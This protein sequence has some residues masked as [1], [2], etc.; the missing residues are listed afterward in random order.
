MVGSW[1]V[2]GTMFAS[3]YS[4]VMNNPQTLD[5][6]KWSDLGDAIVKLAVLF[7]AGGLAYVVLGAIIQWVQQR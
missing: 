6:F 4:V 1:L 5:L 3:A 2:L 7:F